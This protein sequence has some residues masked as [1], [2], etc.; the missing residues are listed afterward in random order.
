MPF[1]PRAGAGAVRE[2]RRHLAASWH[3]AARADAGATLR[4]PPGSSTWYRCSSGKVRGEAAGG[5]AAS[6]GERRLASPAIN[7]VN[8]VNPVGGLKKNVTVQ[9]P[10]Y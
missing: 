1:S 5:S 2:G 9:V 4:Q 6:R 3:L 7:P 8:P 10:L